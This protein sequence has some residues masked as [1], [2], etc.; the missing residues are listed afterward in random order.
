MR[1]IEAH[2]TTFGA[3]RIW[4]HAADRPEH[5]SSALSQQPSAR[6]L[7]DDKAKPEVRRVHAESLDVYGAYKVLASVSARGH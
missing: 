3:E 6:Q 7:S 5:H 2:K 1:Y 4:S